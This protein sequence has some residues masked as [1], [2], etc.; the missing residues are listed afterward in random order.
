MCAAL[1]SETSGARNG[2]PGSSPLPC[3]SPGWGSPPQRPSLSQEPAQSLLS[4]EWGASTP[5]QPSEYSNE[6]ITHSRGSQES[7][8]PPVTTR[9]VSLRLLL[10]LCLKVAPWGQLSLPCEHV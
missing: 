10:T 9:L 2:L 1:T 8:C 3:I 7:P 5:D 4:P 6:P